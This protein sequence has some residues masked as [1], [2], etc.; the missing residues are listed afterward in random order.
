MFFPT[1]DRIFP[2]DG[3]S[4]EQTAWFFHAREGVQG[5][6]PSQDDAVRALLVFIKGCIESG[7]TGG[8]SKHWSRPL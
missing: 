2:S 8:R 3:G 7:Q 4:P 6:Y 5:P 1:G